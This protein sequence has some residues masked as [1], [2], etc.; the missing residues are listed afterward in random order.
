MNDA[1][2]EGRTAGRGLVAE[3]ETAECLCPSC[4]HTTSDFEILDITRNDT[5]WDARGRYRPI[6]C[7]MCG[8]VHE[9]L[10]DRVPIE[11]AGYEC[12]K[13]GPAGTM[14][15]SI[16]KVAKDES[17]YLFS[18]TLR[19]DRCKWRQRFRKLVKPLLKLRRL[20]V[21]PTGVELELSD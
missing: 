18:A 16:V 20:K 1:S 9:A 7:A 3:L 8:Q 21:G 14:K 12:P 11:C 19:C 4:G 10:V 13:C 2:T 17:G 6:T 15:S 5:G